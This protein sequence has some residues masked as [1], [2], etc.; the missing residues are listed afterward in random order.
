[1]I[2][3]FVQRLIDSRWFWPAA[4]ALV[5]F[6]TVFP[7]TVRAW[8]GHSN[9]FTHYWNAAV[10]MRNGQDIYTSGEHRYVYPPLLA[11][12]F[13]PL[14][15]VSQRIATA[16]WICLSGFATLTAVLIV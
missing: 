4:I 11:F 16:I 10:A 6:A 9:D 7:A 1:M 12:L 14:T 5:L 8:H 3:R 15:F 13:E 2:R